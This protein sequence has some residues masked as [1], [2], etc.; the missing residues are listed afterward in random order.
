MGFFSGIK[1]ALK[2]VEIG[3]NIANKATDG[4]IS[5]LDKVKF[6]EEER[7]DARQKAADSIVKIWGLFADENSERSKTRRELAKL[8]FKV[9]LSLI[10]ILMLMYKVDP[11]WCDKSLLIV[12]KVTENTLFLMIAGAYFIPHQLSK[13][14]ILGKLT[15]KKQ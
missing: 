5:G 8:S 12:E 10:F 9:F 15:G 1:A 3:S 11:A 13:L 4:I 6:T 7:A 14:G 2:T